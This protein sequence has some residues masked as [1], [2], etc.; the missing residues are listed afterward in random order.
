VQ[1]LK[2]LLI[3][4]LISVEVLVSGAM[5]EDCIM[6]KDL[7]VQFKNDSTVYINQ[8]EQKGVADFASFMKKTN[9]Y[10]VIEGHTSSVASARRNYDLSTRRASKVRLELIKL[11]VPKNHIR[12]MGFGESSPLYDNSTE[13]GEAKN[14]RV[15]AEVF[16]TSKE[17]NA[18]IKSEKNRIKTIVF[19]EQ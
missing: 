5:A 6:V 2:K 18:Y 10:A 17:L 19:N 1:K 14:K 4:L 16:N 3:S 12:S 11:G 15:I 8:E 9:L 13:E 7:N